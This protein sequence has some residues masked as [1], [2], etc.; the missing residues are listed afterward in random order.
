M[1][2]PILT[3][4]AIIVTGNHFWLDAVGGALTLWAG[5]HVGHRASMWIAARPTEEPRGVSSTTE[6]T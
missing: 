2:Y 5:W 6:P 1:S 4:F 3:T